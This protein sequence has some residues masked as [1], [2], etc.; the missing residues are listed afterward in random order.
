MR[1]VLITGGRA[2]EDLALV[3]ATLDGLHQ[4]AP[5]DLL[6]HGGASGADSLADSW[7]RQMG[8][9]RDIHLA[10]WRGGLGK[11]AGP[12]RNQAMLAA[13]H[14]LELVVAFPGGPGTADMTKRAKAAGVP[15]LWVAPSAL[16][17]ETASL[18]DRLSPTADGKSYINIYSRGLTRLGRDLSNFASI[19]GGIETS[20]GRFK[21]IEGL[22]FFL[23]VSPANPERERLRHLSGYQ[24]KTEGGLLRLDTTASHDERP[25]ET[26]FRAVI[27]EALLAKLLAMPKTAEELIGSTLPF[28]HFYCYGEGEKAK[29]IQGEGQWLVGLWGD[30]RKS[31]KD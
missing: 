31:L 19:P 1:K 9:K 29:V 7:A 5:I 23:G 16:M 22:W 12:I 8:V 13:H 4:E 26:A 24:A 25:T 18:Y 20:Y 27:K 6:V 21:S 17:T 11:K 3:Y 15:I 2:I 28:V 14:D 10:D 30:I